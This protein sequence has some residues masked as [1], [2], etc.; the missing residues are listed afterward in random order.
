MQPSLTL[1]SHHLCPYVQRAAIALAEKQVPFE[2]VW[3]DLSDK[4]S[5]FGKISPLGKVPVLVVR[6][7]KGHETSIFESAVI[8]EYLEET[9]DCSLHPAEP[10]ERARHRGWIECGSQV[11]NAIGRLYSAT[12]EAVFEK[13]R[14]GIDAMFARIEEELTDGPFFSGKRF[15]L[16]DVIFAPVFRYFDAFDRLGQVGMLVGKPKL[17]AWRKALAARPSVRSAVVEDFQER[18]MRFLQA[19][20]GVLV[21]RRKAA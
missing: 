11:L 19:K 18:L 2:R 13:E 21:R 1:I 9:T 20:D 16:V 3:I 8:L 4:P 14:V 12:D 7:A 10:L 17:T 15:S 5:W 6:D